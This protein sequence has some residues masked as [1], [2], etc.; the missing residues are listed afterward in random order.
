M[1]TALAARRFSVA[2]QHW[3]AANSGDWN[4]IHVNSVD[5]RRTV[6][7]E[8]VVHG[9]HALL[10]ALDAHLGTATAPPA[11]VNATF[12]KPTPVESEIRLEREIDDQGTVWLEAT[13]GGDVLFTARMAPGS[14]PPA[15]APAVAARRT[16]RTAPR[17][18]SFDA[19]KDAS[20]QSPIEADVD[21]LNRAFP[22]ACDGLDPMRVAAVMT[23]SRLVGMEC[24]GLHSLLAGVEVRFDATGASSTVE[25]R[26]IRHRV[27]IAPIQIAVTGGGLSGSISA[28]VRTPP[29]AQAPAMELAT[30]VS[31]GE[32]EGQ[33]ALVIGGSRGLGEVVAKVVA[34]GGGDPLITY[35]TGEADAHRVAAEIAG[36]GRTCRI[37]AFN[38]VAADDDA[39]ARLFGARPTHL[40]YFATPRI[41]SGQEG[42]FNSE[43]SARFHAAYVDAFAHLVLAAVGANDELRVF[44]PST[45][46]LNQLPPAQ[47][48]YVAAKAA[49]E[50]VCRLLARQHPRLG[51]LVSRL[52]RLSTDQTA[53]LIGPPP[54]DGAEVMIEVVR[55]IHNLRPGHT[56]DGA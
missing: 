42:R 51:V 27:V 8:M 22:H 9:M 38:A 2:D 25:W 54:Q 53:S 18:L 50:T 48:E 55:R 47:L 24:P 17:S 14:V 35:H 29:V 15:G 16:S 39:R 26:V 56:L 20:G 30:R 19:L 7:G 13:H 32:F 21:A 46:F 6:A 1:I 40:Y 41:G 49:G 23:L 4:P 33:R 10:W 43:L 34:A 12:F 37:E 45:V 36:I 3:F 28:L 52:P 11:A 31:P 44:Y 5:A